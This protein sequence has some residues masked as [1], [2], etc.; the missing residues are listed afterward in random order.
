MPIPIKINVGV[1]NVA[2][3]HNKRLLNERLPLPL[4]LDNYRVEQAVITA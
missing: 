3:A 1:V 2:L 4:A